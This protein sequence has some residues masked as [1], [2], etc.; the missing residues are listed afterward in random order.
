MR[1][2]CKNPC[3]AILITCVLK[4]I[5]I[6]VQ[7]FFFNK[8]TENTDPSC[9]NMIL[10]AGEECD[11]GYSNECTDP[12]CEGADLTNDKNPASCKLKAKAKAHGVL[13]CRYNSFITLKS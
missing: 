1:F 7:H 8:R 6:K 2:R 9:G 10:E 11:C 3:F 4:I 12:C 5:K 13:G